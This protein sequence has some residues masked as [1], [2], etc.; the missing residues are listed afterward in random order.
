MIGAESAL[1]GVIGAIR[2]RDRRALE[3][4]GRPLVAVSPDGSAAVPAV[5]PVFPVANVAVLVLVVLA[6]LACMV[7][8][9]AMAQRSI[10]PAQILRG[11]D[12]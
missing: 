2:R 1:L 10:R 11:G 12:E 7:V 3:L 5:V 9:V 4:A 6:A 8:V